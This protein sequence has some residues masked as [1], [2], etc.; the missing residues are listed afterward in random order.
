MTSARTTHRAVVRSRRRISQ[1]L[2]RLELTT[3]GTLASTG[4]ADE[5][6]ALT[7]PGQFQTRYYTVRSL[8]GDDL[9]LDVVVHDEGL[10][11]GW[12]QTDCVGD[13]VGLGAP[14]GS[15]ELPPDAGWVVLA[16]DLTALPA[17]AR[18]AASLGGTLPL[19]VH[20]ETPDGP[21]PDYLGVEATWHHAEPGSSEL[22]RTVAGLDWPDGPGYF[23]MAGESAQMRDI[24][25]H[26]RRDLGW[27]SKHHE[28]MGYWS[29][30]RGRQARRVDPGPLYARG[31]AA[32]KTDEQI[33]AEYDESR[34]PA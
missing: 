10:V 1:H 21:L 25:R 17:M 3:D 12:A 23:W 22:A 6:L 15:F 7:V 9:V 5:W 11:T 18:I 34:D 33:W 14:K 24:R 26:V 2:L 19:A 31:R 27:D 29:G 32:G 20:A 8:E 28:V 13:E 4:V 16:G 30:S